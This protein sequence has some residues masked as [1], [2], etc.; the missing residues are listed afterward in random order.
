MTLVVV[1]VLCSVQIGSQAPG[2]S[3]SLCLEFPL[4][5]NPDELIPPIRVG[6]INLSRS[7]HLG[8]G[9]VS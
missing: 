2:K 3:E 1:V 4:G 9:R 6:V 5:T 8:L 7:G